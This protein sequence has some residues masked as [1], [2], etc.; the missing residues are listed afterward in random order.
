MSDDLVIDD[1]IVLESEI[2]KKLLN[3]YKDYKKTMLYLS[4]D[5]PISALCLSKPLENLLINNGINR[6]YDIFDVDLAKIKGL[7]DIRRGELA[8]S[9]EKFIPMY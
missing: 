7:G 2:K 8:T 3:S 1:R 5:V 6:I 4:C 9:L